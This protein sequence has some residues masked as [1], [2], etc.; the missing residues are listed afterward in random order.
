MEGVTCRLLSGLPVTAYPFPPPLWTREPHG[1]GAWRPGGQ[2]GSGC[3]REWALPGTSC[4]R[5]LARFGGAGEGRGRGGLYLYPQA[6]VQADPASLCTP[7]A[8]RVDTGLA[9]ARLSRP[10]PGPQISA[11]GLLLGTGLPLLPSLFLSPA[12]AWSW[13]QVALDMCPLR[14]AFWGRESEPHLQL[15][16]S[17]GALS[18]EVSGTGLH[19]SRRDLGE[20]LGQASCTYGCQAGRRA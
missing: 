10:V 17:Q 20:R 11:K 2:P 12:W 14:G 15:P 3:S 4:P 6:C 18:P 5:S 19:G 1:D 7:A 9:T 16:P 13:A 8:F